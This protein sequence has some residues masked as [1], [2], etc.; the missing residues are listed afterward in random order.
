LK[1]LQIIKSKIEKKIGSNT[2]KFLIKKFDF[3][4]N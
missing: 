2:W 4:K 1:K 3:H